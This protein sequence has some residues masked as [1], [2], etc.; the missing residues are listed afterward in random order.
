MRERVKYCRNIVNGFIFENI[1]SAMAGQDM[2]MGI[3][4]SMQKGGGGQ[5]ERLSLIHI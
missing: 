1:R 2:K 3:L 5:W 4:I